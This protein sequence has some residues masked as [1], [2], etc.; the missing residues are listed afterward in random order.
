MATKSIYKLNSERITSDSIVHKKVNDY[1]NLKTYLDNL[2]NDMEE[3][4]NYQKGDIYTIKDRSYVT[5]GGSLT[6]GKG[7]IRFGIFVPK[8]LTNI[9]KITVNSAKIT[10]RNT[11]G[12]YILDYV[13]VTNKVSAS[14]SGDNAIHLSYASGSTMSGTNNTPISVEIGALILTFN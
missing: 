13:D 10:V 2:E 7:Q 12:E 11:A 5:V 14:K 6:A 9:S 8:K 4:L 1:I 3:K